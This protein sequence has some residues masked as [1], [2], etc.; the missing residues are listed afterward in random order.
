MKPESYIVHIHYD[1]GHRKVERYP[2]LCPLE[3]AI[4]QHDAEPHI[5]Y[6]ESPKGYPVVRWRPLNVPIDMATGHLERLS[7]L[8]IREARRDLNHEH[9]RRMGALWNT[10]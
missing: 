5:V 10:P 4:G 8:A 2:L 6:V 1:G 3:L 7:D 9:L